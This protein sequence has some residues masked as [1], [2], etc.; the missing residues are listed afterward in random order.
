MTTIHGGRPPEREEPIEDLE[1][2]SVGDIQAELFRAMFSL[3]L[4]HPPGDKEAGI[5]FT[6]A[7]AAYKDI[8]AITIQGNV[9][10]EEKL[11]ERQ[12]NEQL[13]AA[14]VQKAREEQ[15]DALV[16]ALVVAHIK[17]ERARDLVRRKIQADQV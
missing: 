17:P 5:A 12:Q 2:K 8:L 7:E 10:F 3:K 14:D 9:E 4:P 15:R 6:Q 1:R 11:T 13:S 16:K